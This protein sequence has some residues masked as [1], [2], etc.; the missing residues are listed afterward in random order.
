MSMGKKDILENQVNISNLWCSIIRMK[1]NSFP[2]MY[3]YYAKE[4][5]VIE[6]LVA[7]GN[8]VY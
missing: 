1:T 2:K 5:D 6:A 4:K 7:K 8:E 3:S